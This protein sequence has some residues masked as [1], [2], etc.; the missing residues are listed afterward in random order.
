MKNGIALGLSACAALLAATLLAASGVDGDPFFT[1]VRAAVRHNPRVLTAEARLKAARERFPQSQAAFLP[2]IDLG[3]SRSHNRSDWAGGHNTTEPLSMTL[4][5]TQPIFSRKAIVGMRQ[6]KPHI[7]AAE[8]DLQAAV[9]GVFLDTALV[10]VEVMQT[11]EVARLAE[12]NRNLLKHHLMATRS[13]Y[14]AGEITRTDV[15]HAEA[16]LATAEANLVQA[17]NQLAVVRARFFEQTGEAAPNGLLVPEFHHAL[18]KTS[19]GDLREWSLGRPE[20]VA[21]KLRVAVAE[22]DVELRR[23]GH[24]PSLALTASGSRHRG[25]ETAGTVD[26][27]D[28]YTLNLGLTVPLYAGGSVVSQVRET[29]AAKE[30]QEAEVE[31]LRRV[32][33]REVEAARLDLH[34]AIA[35]EASLKVAL[36][37]A[38]AALDGVEQEFAVGTRTALDLLDAQNAAFTAQVELAKGRFAI[39]TAQ[40]RLL[41]AV[42]QLQY[43]FGDPNLEASQVV[44][45]IRVPGA[46]TEQPKMPSDDP[47]RGQRLDRPARVL[48]EEIPLQPARHGIRLIR[49][50]RLHALNAPRGK[51][52]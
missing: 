43:D 23:S 18:P 15:S 32:I 50:E 25:D 1:S 21:A 51:K 47:P 14:D 16:R 7:A 28:Q 48:E 12:N 45:P 19:L 38:N 39:V 44:L 5:M 13:R 42:G 33:D 2:T 49:A 29:L 40:F 10:I 37:A 36:D 9:Q 6:S 30:A 20:L 35:A 3:A 24:W 46:D 26:P 17:N 41:H 11:R 22:E 31:R 52:K 8:Y 34:S 4:T 27:V